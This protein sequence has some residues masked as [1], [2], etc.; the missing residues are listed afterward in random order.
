M[1]KHEDGRATPNRKADVRLWRLKVAAVV[2]LTSALSST[3]AAEGLKFLPWMGPEMEGARYSSADSEFA[4][5]GWIGAH[6]SLAESKKWSV[7]FN[8]NVETILGHRVRSFEAVQANYSLELGARRVVGRGWVSPFFHHIS[9]HV[10]D[11]EKVRAVDWNFLGLRYESGWPERWNRRGGFSASAA[12][13]TLSSG[14]EYNWE[15]RF[16][17]DLDVIRRGRHALFFLADFR[18]VGAE[19]TPAYPR[20]DVTDFRAETGLRRWQENSQFVIFVAYERR[21]DALITSPLVTNRALFGFR[22]HGQRSSAPAIVPL[23]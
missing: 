10:I 18:H 20:N 19:A 17:G 15:A 2:I 23:P 16:S 13:A 4:W 8:A 3:G 14:V 7:Y 6:V 11:R 1:T 9:R 5:V 12:V 21:A 22:I